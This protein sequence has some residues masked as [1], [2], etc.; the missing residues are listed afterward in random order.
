MYGMTLTKANKAK[1]RM[2]SSPEIEY[3][4]ND[5]TE[6][7]AYLEKYLLLCPPGE[8]STHA[9]LATC[10][11]Q[12]SQMAG[13]SKPVMNAIR[14]VAFLLGEMEDSQISGMLKDAFDTQIMELTAEMA[15]LID[16][17]KSKMDVHFK[18]TEGRLN[19]LL[20]NVAAQ[21]RQAQPVTYASI[22]NISPPHANPRIAAKEGIKSRQFL[23]EGIANTKFSHMDIFQIKTELNIILGGLGL[24][25]GK[26]R[27]I[28]KLPNGRILI[29]MDSDV[30]TTWL[31]NQDN[32]VKFCAKIGQGV[33]FY[34]QV[35]QLIAFNTPLGITPEDPK[36][37]QEVCEANN[38]ELETI[39]MMKWVKPIQ[40]RT[41][42]QRTAHLIVTFNNA[43]TANRAITNG[44]HICNKRC[45]AECQER[46]DKM[47]E[48]PGMESLCQ[49][50]HQ[51]ARQMWKLH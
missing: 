6:G 12:V 18:E 31:T 19:L 16:D 38:L 43:D 41:Q 33:Q 26:I 9:S 49:G 4:I 35:H 27:S 11:H 50:L 13:V 46:A 51:R 42:E 15:V 45:Q 21:P 17:A 44:I 8:P 30:A 32:Q 47:L 7:R 22:A 36:H 1:T 14:A 48:M 5:E 20:D 3:D 29:E 25:D 34:T 10:L 37:R 24:V 40:R 2:E 23:A 39:T 28:S